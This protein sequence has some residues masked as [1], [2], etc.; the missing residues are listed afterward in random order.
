MGIGADRKKRFWNVKTSIRNPPQALAAALAILGRGELVAFPTETVY[1]LGA[2]AGNERAVRRVYQ[3]KARP[4]EDPLIV[5]VCDAPQ[6]REYVGEFSAAAAS[7]AEHFWPGPLTLVLPRGARISPAV[8]AGLDT[9]AIRA[10]SHPVAQEL[11]RRFGRPLAAPSAN[12]F[13]RT[14][15]TTARHVLAE[16]AGYIPLIIDGGPCGIGV[17]STVLDLCDDGARI[18]R[19]GAVTP[20][21]I[22]D[23]LRRAGLAAKVMMADRHAGGQ[24][25]GWKSPGMMVRHYA[26]QTPT[27][28]FAAAQD[29]RVRRW[30]AL[31]PADFHIALLCFPDCPVFDQ[32]ERRIILPA[33]ASACAQRL[34]A[35]LRQADELACGAILVQLPENTEGLWTAILDRITR[36]APELPP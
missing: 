6:A 23:T 4:P 24:T 5:H 14:S 15:P 32:R 29:T 34:Y 7:L 12:R 2:D 31:Q 36:A 10:P 22:A 19:P 26:P 25:G 28:R 20:G 18:L 1:G 16:L 30:L 35:A 8:S 27:Y 9:V 17:E 11:L 3:V 33:D 13:G 21:M